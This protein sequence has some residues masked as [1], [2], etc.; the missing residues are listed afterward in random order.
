MERFLHSFAR[1]RAPTGQENFF[2]SLLRAG[3]GA[4]R[5]LIVDLYTE[6]PRGIIGNIEELRLRSSKPSQRPLCYA[7]L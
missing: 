1:T 2:F 3:F 5:E 7:A 4:L 6:F